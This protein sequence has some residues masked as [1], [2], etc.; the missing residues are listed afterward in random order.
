MPLA[1]V[2]AWPA[3]GSGKGFCCQASIGKMSQD[4]DSCDG[5]TK[6]G[7]LNLTWA[8]KRPQPKALGHLNAQAGAVAYTQVLRLS[9]GSA[10]DALV[11]L[12]QGQALAATGSS[13]Q[14]AKAGVLPPFMEGQW[15]AVASGVQPASH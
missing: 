13:E 14:V 12:Y 15:I 6:A 9:G 5:P 4:L 1:V 3:Q 7:T 11:G 10:E 8:R 2:L